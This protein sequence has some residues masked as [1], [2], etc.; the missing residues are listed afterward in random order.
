MARNFITVLFDRLP[1]YLYNLYFGT[2]AYAPLRS[3]KSFGILFGLSQLLSQTSHTN[4]SLR[5]VNSPAKLPIYV[6]AQAHLQNLLIGWI[7]SSPTRHGYKLPSRQLHLG[8][9]DRYS[10]NSPFGIHQ[11]YIWITYKEYWYFFSVC[12]L[13]FTTPFTTLPNSIEE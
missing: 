13:R 1:W 10:R 5:R 7:G 3:D 8:V 4:K 11:K 12:S 9:G 2:L 6:P